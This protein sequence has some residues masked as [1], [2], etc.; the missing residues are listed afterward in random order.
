MNSGSFNDQLNAISVK[1]RA[2]KTLPNGWVYK[3]LGYLSS[4]EANSFVDG[5]FGSD[6]KS[7]EY[8]D[9]GIP[10]IQLNNIKIGRQDNANLKFISEDKRDQLRRHIARPGDLVIAKMADPVARVTIVSSEFD[11]YVIVADCVKLS[12]DETLINSDFAVFAINSHPINV[13]AQLVSTGTTR[14]RISLTELKKLAIPYPPRELQNLISSFLTLQTKKLDGL[15]EEK[16]RFID[17]L[18]E[19]RQAL[20]SH[21]VTKGLNPNVKMKDSGVEWIGEVPEH[22]DVKKIK[23]IF[24]YITDK[25]SCKNRFT[26]ALENIESK[27]GNLVKTDSEYDADGV[28]FVNG[29]TLFGKLRP[30][31]EKVYFCKK[32]GMSFGDILV[33]RPSDKLHPE[34][35]YYLMSNSE[36]IKVIDS[37]TFGTKMPRANPDY[38][39]NMWHSI[40]SKREQREI[41]EFLNKKLINYQNIQDETKKSIELLKE[42]RTALISAAVTGKIDVRDIVNNQGIESCQV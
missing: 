3:R 22:W 16:Q 10:L 33:F 31:L 25:E 13:D 23:H 28:P 1:D 41:V 29:D 7:E 8:T 5:P 14:V 34:F 38:I 40:P 4:N 36:M 20:I 12:L 21:Y 32:D 2:C 39:R 35:G 30:Y 17:L 11:Q 18:K 15:I 19:K 6:L 24:H 27:T 37:S 9:S 42:H 26:I